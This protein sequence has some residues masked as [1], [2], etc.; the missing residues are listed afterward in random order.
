MIVVTAAAASLLV[1]SQPA[2]QAHH[3][4]HE[5]CP[6]PDVSRYCINIRR[7]QGKRSFWIFRDGG[8]ARRYRL[9]VTA[10]DH[11]RTCKTFRLAEGLGTY[12]DL[13]VWR[14]HFPLQGSGAYTVVWKKLNGQR[15]GR[16]L[17]FHVTR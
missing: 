4:P 12:S 5:W 8:R 2:A 3:R 9:C 7:S 6:T 14:E 17:G 11:S 16:K 13:V 1:V 10:P 15:I